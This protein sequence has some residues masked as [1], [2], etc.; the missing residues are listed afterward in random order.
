MSRWED[1]AKAHELQENDLLLFTCC[2][3]SSF[4]VLVFE[5]SGCEKVSSLFGN[6]IGPNMCKEFND[7]V[8]Q[9][10]EH[11]SVSVSDSEDTI[12]PLQLVRSPNN[13]SPSK[14]PSGKARPSE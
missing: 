13:A 5:A 14:E 11:H 9:H 8:G 3:N 4:E 12:A 1:F 6:G 2:G 7:I 10:G